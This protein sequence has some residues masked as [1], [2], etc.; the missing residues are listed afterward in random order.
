MPFWD[1]F[2]LALYFGLAQHL[3]LG[4]DAALRILERAIARR[5]LALAALS[6][7]SLLLLLAL[8]PAT[9]PHRPAVEGLVT[10]RGLLQDPAHLIQ[11]LQA[12][13]RRRTTEL[14]E[15]ARAP[16]PAVR[17]VVITALVEPAQL[18][19]IEELCLYLGRLHLLDP[20]SPELR[21]IAAGLLPRATRRYLGIPPGTVDF[22][23]WVYRVARAETRSPEEPLPS[24]FPPGPPPGWFQG[25]EPDE[26]R[27]IDPGLLHLPEEAVDLLCLH[28]YAGLTV[29]QI[30]GALRLLQRRGAADAVVCRLEE[31]WLVLL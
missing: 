2:V 13:I 9:S 19:L 16:A 29:E 27:F 18:G 8:F 25:L 24:D 7:T 1:R 17:Q 22:V 10:D 12:V 21:N 26:Q 6:D 31:S 14:T 4:R 23:G 3:P 11:R 30:V 15:I 20:A 5:R 28:F